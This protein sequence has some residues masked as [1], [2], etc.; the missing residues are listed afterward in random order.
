MWFETKFLDAL[1][2]FELDRLIEATHC[3][4][5]A[6]VKGARLIMDLL[7]PGKKGSFLFSFIEK[8]LTLSGY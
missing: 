8:A 6:A 1:E 4:T 5:V 7:V 3:L 2:S